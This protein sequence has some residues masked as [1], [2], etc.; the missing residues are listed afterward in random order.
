VHLNWYLFLY[1]RKKTSVI[2]VKVFSST[3]QNL[4]TVT[5]VTRHSGFVHSLQMWNYR[6]CS[7]CLIMVL[8]Q[9]PE[10]LQAVHFVFPGVDLW[11]IWQEWLV[12]A[13]SSP[14]PPHGGNKQTGPIAQYIFN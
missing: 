7:N 4:V 8:T 5:W 6:C 14:L 3:I 9:V 1:A 12:W 13:G 10:N 11:H 2:I